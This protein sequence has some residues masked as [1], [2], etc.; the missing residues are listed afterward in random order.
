LAVGFEHQ[1][2]VLAWAGRAA[3]KIAADRRAAVTAIDQLALHGRLRRPIDFLQAAR[4]GHCVIAAIGF[5]LNP[6]RFDG[7]EPVR[8]FGFGYEIAPAELDRIEA[9]LGRRNV[10]QPLAR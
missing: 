1:A 8:H 10:A 7:S 6:E 5:A 9:E 4:E 2:R 3:L